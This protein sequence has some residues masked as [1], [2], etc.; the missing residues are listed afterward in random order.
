M[1]TISAQEKKESLDRAIQALQEMKNVRGYIIL[2]I[3]EEPEHPDD[4]ET[5]EVN[6]VNAICGNQNTFNHLL[7]NLNESVLK[8]FFRLKAINS[9]AEFFDKQ[10]LSSIEGGERGKRKW[11]GSID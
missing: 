9:L 2:A 8:H 4:I 1:K 3:E 5:I 11:G 10:Y 6:G 7:S